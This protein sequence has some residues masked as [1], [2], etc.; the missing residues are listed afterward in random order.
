MDLVFLVVCKIYFLL[1]LLLDSN[2]I[3]NTLKKGL[4]FSHGMR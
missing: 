3:I 1:V 2:G 4:T